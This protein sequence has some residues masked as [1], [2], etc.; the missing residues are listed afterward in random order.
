L[1]ANVLENPTTSPFRDGYLRQYGLTTSGGSAATRYYVAAEWDGFGGVYGLPTAERA[2][3]AGTGGLHPEVLNPNYVRRVNLRGT[4]QVLAGPR[5]DV[6]LVGGYY[7]GDVR[8]PLNDTSGVGGLLESGLLGSA[9]TAVGHGWGSNLPGD[10][11]QVLTS[12][13]VERVTASLAGRWQPLGRLTARLVAGLD[14]ASQHDGQLQ[15][16]GEGPRGNPSLTR[17]SQGRL[18]SN[19]YSVT[20][21]AAAAWPV[22]EAVTAR[23]IGGV[24]YFKHGGDVLD[25]AATIYGSAGRYTWVRSRIDATTT[26][27]FLEQQFAWRDRLF[28]TGLLRRDA[29]RQFGVSAPATVNSQVGVAWRLPTAGSATVGPWRLRAAYGSAGKQPSV[30]AVFGGFVLPLVAVAPEIK[31]ER[32]R[33][34]E[35]GMDAQLLGGRLAVSATVYDRHT[36]HILSFATTAPSFGPGVL[37]SDSGAVTNKGVELALVAGIVRSPVVTWDV[38]LSAWGNRNRVVNAGSF[39]FRVGGGFGVSQPVQA[40][41][42]LG[43]FTGTPILGYRDANRDGVLSPGE[44]Q[45]GGAPV[46]LGTPLPTEGATLS[47]ALGVLRRARVSALFEY[48]AGNSVVNYTGAFRCLSGNCRERNDPTTPLGEQVAWAAWQAGSIAGWVEDAK[49]LK[50]REVAVTFLAPATWARFVGSGEMHLTLAGRNLATWTSYRGLDPEVSAG[51]ADVL[52]ATDFFTQ[53]QAR[54]WTARLDLSF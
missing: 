39:P 8:L 26:G 29:T 15:R 36:T 5:G 19:R 33:E 42:P 24:Q 52:S 21:T 50:L 40:G 4:G 34:L 31:P 41:V 51:G 22:S 53:P 47:T 25:S 16:P 9:D 27:L 44:V 13:H 20:L 3:L 6:T 12:Q 1:R 35:A 32:T 2:R 45:L 7:S 43:S 18:Q 49:F 17:V 46:F 38:G 48:R 11:F 10:I 37:I 23:T 54:Y 14:R 28:L 30:S